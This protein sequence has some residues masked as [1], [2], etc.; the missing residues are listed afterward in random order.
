MPGSARGARPEDEDVLKRKFQAAC[1]LTIND[2]KQE[3]VMKRKEARPDCSTE[4]LEKQKRLTDAIVAN[5]RIINDD[6]HDL[7]DMEKKVGNIT[8][9][10]NQINEDE[11]DLDALEEQVRNTVAGLKEIDEREAA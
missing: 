1:E 11:T 10:L 7:E 2:H 5:L 9:G 3:E 8:A 4:E 6:K